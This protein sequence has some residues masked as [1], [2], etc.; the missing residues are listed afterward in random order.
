MSLGKSFAKLGVLL[1]IG[2]A[3]PPATQATT[4]F[5]EKFTCPVGGETFEDYVIGSYST[6][7]Q[8]PDGR[9]YG[10]LPIYPIVE[11]PGN[12]FLLFQDEFTKEEIAAL[13][14]LVASAEYQAM[15]TSETPNYRAW[16]LM[17]RLGRDPLELT[18]ALLRASWESDHDRDRKARYQTAFVAAA[19][20]LA[21]SSENAEPWFWYNLRASN[22]L[23]E[24][25]QF[26]EAAALL[27][28]IDQPALL[29][30]DPDQLEGARYLIDGLRVLIGERNGLS[31][32]ASL[33]PVRE[34]AFRC[35]MHS[36]PLSPSEREACSGQEVME[37]IAEFSVEDDAGRKLRGEAAVRYIL[38]RSAAA[39]G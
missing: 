12:G 11:C 20:G 33:I 3:T 38:E 35:V 4:M 36:P 31:E 8:R 25:G 9:S 18:S 16:W 13:E 15:R 24:L 21:R 37:E 39:E 26:V 5:P 22:A 6:F 28:R 14:P 34:A 19:T 2:V 10:T 30:A 23:R 17:T 27:D 7:G 29:P 1:A 32:P